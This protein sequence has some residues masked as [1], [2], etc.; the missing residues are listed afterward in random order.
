MGAP[1]KAALGIESLLKISSDE[2][3]A[4]LARGVEAIE[5]EVRASG[6]KEMIEC[7][8]YVLHCTAGVGE[9]ADIQFSNGKRDR[10]RR[11]ETFEYFCSHPDAAAAELSR[12]HVLALRLY[13]TAAFRPLNQP[14]RFP[15]EGEPHP[16][17]ATIAFISDGI[18][19]LRAVEAKQ[20]KESEDV[21]EARDLWR[22]MCNL[23]ITKEFF[24][25]GGTEFA[26]MSTTD[27]IAIAVQYSAGGGKALLLK[28]KTN[29]FMERGANLQFLSAFPEEKEFLFPPLTYMQPTGRRQSLVV[30]QVLYTVVEVKP[31]M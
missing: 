31:Q 25:T 21:L 29:S 11:G 30:G 23:E 10:G 18:K 3:Y 24:A 9:R 2:Y 17:P 28:V 20:V 15:K 16:F 13:T 5:E 7:L 12:A 14:L 22:G 27:D 26:P 19:K 1:D 8:D 4:R 6:N